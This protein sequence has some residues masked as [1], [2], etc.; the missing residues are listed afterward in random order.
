MGLGCKKASIDESVL[1]ETVY[2]IVKRK[3]DLVKNSER[4]VTVEYQTKSQK[5]ETE[6]RDCELRL[7]KLK[8]SQ[9][10]TLEQFLEGKLT[11]DSFQ[12]EKLKIAAAIQ[13][14]VERLTSLEIQ[15]EN[16]TEFLESHKPY[17]NQETLTREML[18][19]LIKEIRITTSDEME[20]VWKFG[21]FYGNLH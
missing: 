14:V 21:S 10:N 17:F 3:L 2:A 5:R 15:T 13:E 19:D 12:S 8:L 1:L 11:K 6:R 9:A 20:I 18:K 4:T 7:K 16:T